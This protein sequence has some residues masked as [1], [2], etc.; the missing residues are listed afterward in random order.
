M[1][2]AAKASSVG[3]PGNIARR[4]GIDSVTKLFAMRVKAKSHVA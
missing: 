2:S 1:L 3:L 4:L